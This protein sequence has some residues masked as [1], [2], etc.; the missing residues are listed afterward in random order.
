MVINI[1]GSFFFLS[2]RLKS[3][4]D[5]NDFFDY[6]DDCIPL[7]TN[8]N[9]I[10]GKMIIDNIISEY[11][12]SDNKNNKLLNKIIRDELIFFEKIKSILYNIYKKK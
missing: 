7:G 1:F 4:I 6:C 12:M 10:K 3:K 5:L 8:I 9:S 2:R 11:L